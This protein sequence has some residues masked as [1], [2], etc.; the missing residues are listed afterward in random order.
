MLKSL[1]FQNKTTTKSFQLC[2]SSLSFTFI[3]QSNLQEKVYSGLFLLHLNPRLKQSGS[4]F[5]IGNALIKII[6]DLLMV[7]SIRIY[8]AYPL[9]GISLLDKIPLVFL[10]LYFFLPFKLVYIPLPL[11]TQYQLSSKISVIFSFYTLGLLFTLPQPWLCRLPK[12]FSL[13][14][15]VRYLYYSSFSKDSNLVPLKPNSSCSQSKHILL[16]F[17][18]FD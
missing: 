3:S 17:L 2:I 7:K 8:V 1:L 15:R 12:Q 13:D 4:Q 18:S 5:C 9:C 6:N 10:T 14:P 16:L 11:C